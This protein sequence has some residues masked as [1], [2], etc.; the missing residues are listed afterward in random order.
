[1]LGTDGRL[2]VLLMGTDARF[3]RDGE[4]IDT[5]IVATINPRTGRVVMVS[6]PRDTVNVP[7][8]NGQVYSERINALF[9]SYLTR[10]GNRKQALRRMTRSMAY[11]FDTEIDY[12]AMT[13]F[14]GVERLIKSIAGV[15]VVLRSPLVDRTINR[16]RGLVL[17]RG[18]NHLNGRTALAFARSRHSDSDYARAARQQ[19]LIGAATTKVLARG[20]D[21]L[22][23]L[24]TLAERNIE[25]NIPMSS[26]STLY[27]LAQHARV[28]RYRSIVLQPSTYAREIGDT[29]TT[30]LDI[31][32]VRNMFDRLFGPVES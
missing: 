21:R 17:K 4:R 7:I 5:I 24:V 22:S 30:E 14:V 23:R 2:T 15:D 19:Q 8:G 25:T 10:T 13:R 16:P 29:F 11:A 31:T 27:E 18:R 6:L 9:A 12:Y 3:N 28:D 20:L 26:A 1:M 32:V